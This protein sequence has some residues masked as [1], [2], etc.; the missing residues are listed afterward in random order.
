MHS[1]VSSEYSSS[2]SREGGRRGEGKEGVMGNGGCEGL[3][4]GS[5]SE[6][7]EREKEKK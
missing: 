1:F 5:E 7:G 2:L 6:M 3:K 4:K